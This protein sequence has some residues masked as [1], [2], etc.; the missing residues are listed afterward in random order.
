MDTKIA[1]QIAKEINVSDLREAARTI[2]EA[3]ENAEDSSDFTVDF[4]NIEYRII[5]DDAIETIHRASIAE[6][7]DDCYDLEGMKRK[8]GNLAAYM[9]FDYDSF[10]RD[11][12]MSDGYGH[13]FS[14]YDGEEIEV[15]NWHI[16]RTN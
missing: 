5:H 7:V 15:E 11:C 2:L 12:R 14:S 16:F 4:G 10:A 9:E 8:M 13:H 1:L 3:F 6:M